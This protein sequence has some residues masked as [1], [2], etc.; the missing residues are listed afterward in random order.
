MPDSAKENP[1]NP[2]KFSDKRRLTG[3][4][5]TSAQNNKSAQGEYK[6][7]LREKQS[8]LCLVRPCNSGVSFNSVETDLPSDENGDHTI[9]QRAE[10]RFVPSSEV[11]RPRFCRQ[12]MKKARAYVFS[13]RFH[14]KML[15]MCMRGVRKSKPR[16]EL[17]QAIHVLL[18]GMCFYYNPL[19]NS[20]DR[21][22]S[23]LAME[24][25]LA[26]VSRNGT[27]SISRV[28]RA[29]QALEKQ[30]GFIVRGAAA[31]IYFTPELFKALRIRPDHLRAARRKCE[32]QQNK[33]G[34]L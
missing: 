13:Y 25:G 15:V 26:T 29:I 19:T 14:I 10:P 17:L 32:R 12:L 8:R 11:I 22:F 3:F 9:F 6:F 24:C 34:T 20:V 16:P 5:R 21:S 2:P 33:R 18:Q 4:T 1:E 23:E 31:R 30:F 27:V 28:T 7:M